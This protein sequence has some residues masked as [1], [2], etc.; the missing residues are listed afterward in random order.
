MPNDAV[1]Y[2][3][4]LTHRILSVSTNWD[5][6][7]IANNAQSHTLAADVVGRNLF[8][9]IE[10]LEVRHLYEILVG[11]VLKTGLGATVPLNCDSP[12]LT[13]KILLTIRPGDDGA[14]EYEGHIAAIAPREP[15]AILDSKRPKSVEM[16]YICSFCKRIDAK[17]DWIDPAIYLSQ[18][19]TLAKEPLPRISHGLCPECFSVA[20]AEHQ[21]LV[22]EGR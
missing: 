2:R 22:K 21:R 7:A 11:A 17:D 10:G 5:D 8:D 3:T 6:F 12:G 20:M 19:G 4:D 9:L 18:R 13:R 14:I 1:A 16:L 15:V